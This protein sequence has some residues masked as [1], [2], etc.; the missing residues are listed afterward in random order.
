MNSIKIA[1]KN[2]KL[3]SK[4]S[5]E[6][7][8]PESNLLVL[9]GKNGVGKTSVVK[10]FHLINDPEIFKKSAGDNAVR[11]NT[12]ISFEIVGWGSYSFEL[13]KREGVLDTRDRLPD[14]SDIIAELPIPYG[15]RFRQFSLIASFDKDIRTAIAA[16]QYAAAHGLNSFLQQVYGIGKF[17]PL[18]ETS[19]GKNTVYFVLLPDDYYIREDHL[20]S[21]EFFLIQLYRLITSGAKLVLVDELD[22][23]LDASAQVKLFNAIKPLLKK[24]Q[25]R[26]LVISHSL[27]FMSTVDDGCL[28][29]ME[30]NHGEISLEKRSF[31][32]IKS[33]LYGFSGFDR[34]ILTEDL[35]LEGFIEF[36]IKH[37]P[38]TPYYQH[39]TIGVGGVNQLRM[40]LERNDQD[41]I[42]SLS[43]N[44]IAVAD[45]D[46][47]SEL[48]RT[49]KGPT[50]LFK[51]PV[52]DLELCIFNHRGNILPEIEL[53][54]FDE[55]PN[56]KKASKTY[57]K[58]LTVD[59][60]ITTNRLYQLIVDMYPNQ[61]QQF[62]DKIE[63]FLILN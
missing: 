41:Q 25:T 52:K 60:K 26:L 5:I 31:G 49:Y 13:N 27:A 42:F 29:Y 14:T 63:Q 4:L 11:A 39:R 30:K 43:K 20:S 40:L 10:A 61:A 48:E 24:Y 23:A 54:E 6:F 19:I 3:I 53:P 37:F 38:I 28:Y 9:T 16:S 59:K 56:T 51:S 7:I 55:S 32:Y 18:Q 50:K 33:D 44:V 2:V 46:V 15:M 21:G 17:K 36:I 58:Y 8:F 1:L 45:G 62:A 34:Y 35:V 22:V 57:W 12:L 47:F